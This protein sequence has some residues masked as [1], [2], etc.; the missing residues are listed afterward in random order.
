M[1]KIMKIN[2]NEFSHSAST[3][4]GSSGSPILL[5]GTNKVIGI[6][7]SGT[8][9][10]SRNFGM[11]IGPIFQYLKNFKGDKKQEKKIVENK[12][13]L[14]P[15]KLI[16]DINL[17]NDLK[18]SRRINNKEIISNKQSK[19][20]LNQI[21][22][23]YD[24][25]NKQNSIFIFGKYFVKNNKNNCNL[26]INGKKRELCS[27]LY[28]NEINIQNNIIEIKLI[29]NKHITNMSNMFRDYSSLV[30]LPDISKWNT[31]NVTDMNSIFSN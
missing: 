11:F 24:I 9:N 6:H 7:K 27:K 20:E 2:K 18:G 1:E 16:K 22:L 19:N 29:E 3:E 17:N 5:K 23:L 31:M 30:S 14:L 28:L 26:L 15:I 21:T 8:S 13:E 25:G 4:E 10:N 12:I